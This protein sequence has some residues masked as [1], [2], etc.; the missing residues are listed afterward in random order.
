[1]TSA[2]GYADR[3]SSYDEKGTLNLTSERETITAIVNKSHLLSTRIKTSTHVVFHTGAGIS[4]TAGIADFRGPNGI[5]TLQ[6]KQNHPNFSRAR[7]RRKVQSFEDAFPTLTHMAIT[8]LHATGHVRYVVSQNVDSLHLRSGLPRH[9]LSELHGNLFMRW[10]P[11]C[12]D[13]HPCETEV[14]TV[15]MSPTCASCP[16]CQTVLTDKALD[17]DDELPHLDLSRAKTECERADFCVVLGTSCQMEPARGLPFLNGRKKRNVALVNL[18]RTSFDERI[19]IRLRANCDDVFTIVMRGLG[20]R[21]GVYERRQVLQVELLREGGDVTCWMGVLRDGVAVRRVIDG[22]QGVRYATEQGEWGELITTKG[23]DHVIKSTNGV[24]RAQ[25][26]LCS[27]ASPVILCV[28]AGEKR[29]R[30]D[31]VTKRID[32]D[33]VA[34]Q[35]EMELL[36][37]ATAE[38]SVG[39]DFSLADD[40][41]VAGKRRGWAV[42][43]ICQAQVWCS[44][45]LRLRHLEE[46]H[47]NDKPS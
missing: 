34:K 14:Q 5:W 24:I 7:K 20:I 40:W 10:C 22:V 6:Q 43:C 25:I 28:A 37:E 33:A 2:Q 1:M 17:W 18:S 16:N 35:R 3:L 4:T 39:L 47:N 41:F 36:R 45:G 42:C 19:G 30:T 23:Y 26:M 13:E 31:V 15:G 11:R 38:T 8:A 46:T 32:W 12:C 29:A 44:K 27:D 21:I 9:A